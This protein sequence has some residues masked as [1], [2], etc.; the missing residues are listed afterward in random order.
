MK[1]HFIADEGKQTSVSA[2]KR[3][4]RA[5]GQTPVETADMIIPVGGDGLLLSALKLAKGRYVYGI[6]PDN[7]ESK[8]F[9]LNP[10][11]HE[12]NLERDLDQA[13]FRKIAPLKITFMQ[14]SIS[15]TPQVRVLHAFNSA[16]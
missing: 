6:V 11:P 2:V 8:G 12:D 15:G 4:T 13:G 14:E 9:A 7:N 16:A 1:A 10:Y 3:L 5:Y